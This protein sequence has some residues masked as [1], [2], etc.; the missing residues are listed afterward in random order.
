MHLMKA[1]VFPD[2]W[3]KMNVSAAKAPFLFET[4]AEM[5]MNATLELEC[6][7]DIYMNDVSES[8]IPTIYKSRLA[9]LMA[10]S[11]KHGNTIVATKLCTIEYC[12]HVAIIF[13]ETLLNCKVC[14]NS[15]NI[16]K[17][18]MNLQ[19]SLK[20]FEDWKKCCDSENKNENFLPQI[21]YNNLQ[22]TVCGFMA[23]TWLVLLHVDEK[24]CQKMYVPALHSN[25]STLESW[26]LL[27]P[28]M[29]KDNTR[30]YGTT[31]S[32]RNAA[33][34]IQTIKGQRNKSYCASDV[35]T[36]TES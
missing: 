12:M 19:D 32:T 4:I 30:D 1:A 31:V 33:S 29:H 6:A 26:F 34:G 5:M 17:H 36:T 10:Y 21:T 16:A 35:G 28:S 24:A 7:D 23:Y 11:Q 27:V 25:M 8:D 3:N 14:F 18:E 20:Y 22:M 2:G 13:N 9:D 15:S